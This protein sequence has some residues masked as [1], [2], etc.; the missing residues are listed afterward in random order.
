MKKQLSLAL[1]LG[2]MSACA[3]TPHHLLNTQQT[4]QQQLSSQSST[5]QH[6]DGEGDQITVSLPRDFSRGQATNTLIGQAGLRLENPSLGG[7]FVSP[8]IKAPFAFTALTASWDSTGENRVWLR[9]SA[10]GQSWSSWTQLDIEK[11]HLLKQ[12]AQFIQYRIVLGPQS[13]FEGLNFQFGRQVRIQPPFQGIKNIS[14]P[15]IVS[16]AEWGAQPPKHNYDAH[17]PI[18]IVIHHTWRPTQAQ[19]TG[20]GTMRGIQRYHQ[21]D[22]KWS[23]IGYHFVIGPEGVIFQGRPETVVGAHSSPNTGMIGICVVGDYDP[24]QDP[25]TPKSDESLMQLLTWLTSEYQINT[26]NFFGH[27]DF[28]T[29]SCPGDEVYKHL[30]RFKQD[31]QKNLGLLQRFMR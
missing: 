14:K 2:L 26:D 1:A 21:K 10:D 13:S 7:Q 11:D 31:V 19:Y 22:K 28:S 25:F 5:L 8:S 15:A 3:T 6:V 24:G 9:S 23:D 17:K 12:P 29:K 27:R 30:D 16:R 20:A 18:G 4:P